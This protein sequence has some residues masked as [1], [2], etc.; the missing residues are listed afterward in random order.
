MNIQKAQSIINE[1]LGTDFVIYETSDSE[2]Y[3][4]AFYK[5]KD[6]ELDDDRGRLIGV[7]PVVL[8]KETGVYKLLSSGEIVMGD[9]FDLEGESEDEK[10]PDY[11]EIKENILR[12]NYVN[13]DDVSFLS[14][15]WRN[16]FVDPSMFITGYKGMDFR[17]FILVE[18]ENKDFINFITEYWRDLNLSFEMVSE[19]KIMLKRSK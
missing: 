7:G 19:S 14:E 4:F 9:Y 1:E 6:Y 15:N 8:I 11:D 12:R 18:C 5:H 3:S 10:I 13:H 2:K 17:N 16:Q